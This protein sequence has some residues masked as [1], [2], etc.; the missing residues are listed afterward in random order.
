MLATLHE[1]LTRA[2]ADESIQNTG[3]AALEIKTRRQTTDIMTP[4]NIKML[5]Q[6]KLE[7]FKSTYRNE[8][9]QLI[10]VPL[11][12]WTTQQTL[13][14]RRWIIHRLIREH[15]IIDPQIAQPSQVYREIMAILHRLNILSNILKEGEA[16]QY[17]VGNTEIVSNPPRYSSTARSTKNPGIWHLLKR[18][19]SGRG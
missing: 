11:G 13:L 5:G 15:G 14:V 2:Q 4:E 10:G 6:D 8:I 17:Q 19:V 7:K 3:L 16:L 18:W 1:E 12:Q 9:Q